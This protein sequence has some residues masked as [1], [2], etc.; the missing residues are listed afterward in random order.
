MSD[1]SVPIVDIPVKEVKLNEF[2]LSARERRRSATMIAEV[3]ESLRW[4]KSP[5]SLTE[6][7]C[8][9]SKFIFKPIPTP[10]PNVLVE[11]GGDDKLLYTNGGEVTGA[12]LF[13]VGI[14]GAEVTMEAVDDEAEKAD[15][16]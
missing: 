14:E 8:A 3:M 10:T 16:D 1:G 11:V 12:I 15:A 13:I 2:L 4:V 5:R 7:R 6:G 9:C